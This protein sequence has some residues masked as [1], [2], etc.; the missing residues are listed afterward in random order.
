LHL[1][2]NLFTPALR[3]PCTCLVPALHLLVPQENT[4]LALEVAVLKVLYQ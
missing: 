1:I 2:Y 4:Q 3:L